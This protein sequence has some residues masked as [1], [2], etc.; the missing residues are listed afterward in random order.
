LTYSRQSEQLSSA[1]PV[2]LIA[3]DEPTMRN[4]MQLALEQIGFIVLAAGDGDEALRLSREYSA[5][6]DI[7]VSDVV[8]PKLDGLELYAALMK[9][10]PATKALLVSGY[11][12]APLRGVPFLRK[13][14]RLEEFRQRVSE[15]LVD[16]DGNTRR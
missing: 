15:M 16:A 12:D 5:A 11:V 3:D 1:K 14:F 4:V 6:I 13:P 10:R 8:M 7:L 9:E 2:A